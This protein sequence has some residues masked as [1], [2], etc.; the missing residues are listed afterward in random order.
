V[1]AGSAVVLNPP[2]KLQ[3]NDR[4]TVKGN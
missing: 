1:E 2:K 4:V 3:N